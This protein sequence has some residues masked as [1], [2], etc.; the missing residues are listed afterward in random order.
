MQE[1]VNNCNS[2]LIY[3][4]Y[5]Y[6]KIHSRIIIFIASLVFLYTPN[7]FLV[8]FITTNDLFLIV[9]SGFFL[10]FCMKIA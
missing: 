3:L 1:Y 10:I 2:M 4:K 8:T 5:T 6:N 9:H 7:I